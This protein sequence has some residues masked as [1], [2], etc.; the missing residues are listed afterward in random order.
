MSYQE[1]AT[2]ILIVRNA[3]FDYESGF[4]KNAPWFCNPGHHEWQISQVLKLT[5]YQCWGGPRACAWPR[6]RKLGLLLVTLPKKSFNKVS[7]MRDSA[8]S[9]LFERTTTLYLYLYEDIFFPIGN[10]YSIWI[11]SSIWFLL[12]ALY[13][14]VPFQLLQLT[15]ASSSVVSLRFQRCPYKRNNKTK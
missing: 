5:N 6:C 4:L 14:S 3:S 15:Y 9:G 12:L 7:Y 13:S 8:H 2:R 11:S 10:L 1:S